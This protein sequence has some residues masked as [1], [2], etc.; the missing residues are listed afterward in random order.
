MTRRL[1]LFLSGLALLS[2]VYPLPSPVRDAATG[3]WA[4]GFTMDYPLWHLIFTPFCSLADF[5]TTLSEREAFVLIA[6]V[7]LA[8]IVAGKKRGSAVFL[9]FLGFVAWGALLP[10]PMGKLVAHDPN[11]LLMDFHS[12]T[13]Y[14]HDGRPSFTPQA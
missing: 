9:F 4:N 2:Q 13:Q 5:L 6:Y 3:L 11:V 7:V 8:C 14:S 1:P 12:H 10:R